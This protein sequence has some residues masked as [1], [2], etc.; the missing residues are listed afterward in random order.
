MI[1]QATQQRMAARL[2]RLYGDA[3]P[4][5]LAELLRRLETFAPQLSDPT[6]SQWDP[7]DCVLIT[8]GDMVREQQRSPLASL[9]DFMVD[10]GWHQLIRTVHVLPFYPWSSD[11]GFSVVDYDQVDPGLGDWSD[12]SHLAEHF[13]LAFDLVL[14]HVSRQGVWFASYVRGDTPYTD[15]FLEVDPATDLSDVIRPRSLPLL[16]PVETSRGLRHVWTTFSEDQ[17]DLNFAEPQVLLAILDVL[18]N[19]VSRGAQLIRLDAIAFLWKEIGT[20]CLH[21]EQT[22]T[23]V[24][25]M[26]DI[27]TAVAPHVWLLTET[28]VPHEENVSYFGAGDEAQLVYQFSLPP[29]LLLAFY[30]GDATALMDWLRQLEAPAAGTTYLNFTASHDGIGLRPLEG[31][32]PVAQVQGLVDALCARGGLVSNRRGADGSDVPYELNMSYVDAIA[33]T[34]AAGDGGERFLAS[35]AVMLGLQ[36]IPAIYFHSLVGSQNDEDAAC[37]SGQPRR[38][39]RRKFQRDQLT[40]QLRE[41]GSLAVRI[42]E[43]YRQL[44]AVRRQ[45]PAFHPDARQVALSCRY[46]ALVAFRRETDRPHESILVLANVGHSELQVDVSAWLPAS[47]LADLI[48]G[49]GRIDPTRVSLTAGQACWLMRS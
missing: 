42:Y 4:S 24:K 13:R 2:Q 37:Q 39:N 25:L 48:A 15:F 5:C 21:L 10:A 9:S 36:G 7:T 27:L 14:N 40:A 17:V 31:L 1:D 38:I 3:A 12:L 41:S 20:S 47:Q 16:T 19:Y 33:S 29:L 35:Q 6:R 22:H 45:Q 11:D 28:N 23:V 43:G 46:P 30:Q 26:R 32:V 34:A 8:Y 44:L 49:H 18:L